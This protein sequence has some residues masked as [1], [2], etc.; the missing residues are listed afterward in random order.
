MAKRFNCKYNNPV[1]D[2]IS[3]A[4]G[5]KISPQD[6][7]DM[8]GRDFAILCVSMQINAEQQ[9]AITGDNK[10]GGVIPDVIKRKMRSLQ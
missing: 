5:L 3:V 8:E 6:V 9:K 4:Q 1:F 10:K 7:L 2:A